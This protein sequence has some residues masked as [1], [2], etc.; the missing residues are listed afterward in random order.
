VLDRSTPE[1]FAS[2][3]AAIKKLHVVLDCHLVAEV[4]FLSETPRLQYRWTSIA[5]TTAVDRGRAYARPAP[6][7]S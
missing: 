3:E 7:S 1:R 4:R 2:F 6:S 5:F